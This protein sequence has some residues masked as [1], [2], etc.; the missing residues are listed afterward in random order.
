MDINLLVTHPFLMLWAGQLLHVLKKVKELEERTP[1][2]TIRKYVLRHKYGVLFSLVG[3]LVAYAMLFEMGELSAVTAFMAG[4]MSDSL[5][6]AAASR[7]K[8]KV[9]GDPH[10][11]DYEDD[12]NDPST[13]RFDRPLRDDEL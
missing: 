13:E 6:D 7:V 8:R 2:V 9:S 10:Y 11:V 5:I 4:Y 3:G 1:E 12:W